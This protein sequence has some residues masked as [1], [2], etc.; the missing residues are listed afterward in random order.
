MV[1]PCLFGAET[2]YAL[3]AV[4]HDGSGA[5]HI[6][7]HGA[8]MACAR[9][10]LP[11]LPHQMR[12][13]YPSLF[14]VNGGRLYYD[15]GYRVEYSSPEVTSP[16]E[17]VR[18]LRA[19]DVVGERVARQLAVDHPE[20]RE[21]FC[22][23]ASIDYL[24]QTAWG[25]HESY[26]IRD[27]RP[28]DLRE[29]LVPFLVS[30]IVYTGAG[31]FDAEHGG[32]RFLIMPRASFTTQTA[33]EN[34]M[35]DRPIFSTRDSPLARA[36][37]RRLHVACGETLSSDLSLFL[38][39]GATA[40]VA[41]VLE[42]APSLA[43]GL[44]LR[45]PVGALRTIA[46]DPTCRRRVSLADGRLMSATGIQRGYL[47]LVESRIGHDWMPA[48]AGEVCTRW[49]EVLDC[50]DDDPASLDTAL[51]WVIKWR[52]Y[53]RYLT[54]HG[55]GPR[56]LHRHRPGA[57][58]S[59]QTTRRRTARGAAGGSCRWRSRRS[60]TAT[61]RGRGDL[62]SRVAGHRRCSACARVPDEALRD[63]HAMGRAWPQGRV[64]LTRRARR[65]R[66]PRR[67]MRPRRAGG[68]TS[69]RRGPCACSRRGRATP[70]RRAA[71]DHVRMGGHRRRRAAARLDGSVRT[72]GALGVS[73]V[74]HDRLMGGET[75]YALAARDADGRP[76]DQH[77]LVTG[78][79]AFARRALPYSSTSSVNRFLGNGCLL[80][81]DPT[82]HLEWSSAEC[83]SPHDAVRYLRA[84]DLIVERLVEEFAQARGFESTFC[85]RCN[86][87]YLSS[88]SW[89]S[90]ESYAHRADPGILPEQLVPFLA[91]RVIY[92]G[93]GGWDPLV[94][95]LRFMLAPRARFTEEAVGHDSQWSRP[96]FHL[97]L[98]SLSTTGT[99]RLHVLCGES[100]CSDLASL[101]RFG[102]TALVVAIVEAGDTPG[103]GLAMC[104]PVN[105]YRKMAGDA[106]CREA[107]RLRSGRTCTAIEL[108]RVLPGGGRAS[109]RQRV[110][111]RVG[112]ADLRVVASHAP[113]PRDR[114]ATDRHVARLGHQA[115]RLRAPPSPVGYRVGGTRRLEHPARAGPRDGGPGL[116]EVL[117]PEDAGGEPA[118][119]D[120]G[121]I[122]TLAPLARSMGL[123]SRELPAFLA[124]RRAAF[125]IDMRFGQLGSAGVFVRSTAPACSRTRSRASKTSR[126][127][128]SSRRAAHARHCGATSCA[129]CHRLGRGTALSGHGSSISTAVV[130]STSATRSR[131][132]S[133]GCRWHRSR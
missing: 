35:H 42:R 64:S 75:E 114:R 118:T 76:V 50:L 32:M 80:G 119:L 21:V 133:A 36:P 26:L 93:A 37:Y 3:A 55:F 82:A 45:H 44:A 49:R 81:V 61:P 31:G 131:Q 30:R 24:H 27:C 70:V 107:I 120:A 8:F 73:G 83:T 48:W 128:P 102:A 123:D 39:T 121:A 51:D 41:R 13:D 84:G 19:G 57:R 86:V 56:E 63:R 95:G 69:P 5:P 87:D 28:A 97:K 79:M 23:R 78:V 106:S 89:A 96:I 71:P 4:A 124:A 54:Q 94:P 74:S 110:A 66:A 59:W 116:Y 7:V 68:R 16:W 33:A 29:S 14:L 40:L 111:S 105:A 53:R 65:T 92:A 47:D 85:S 60:G 46:A 109:A 91:S 122:E 104:A 113:R 43:A 25:A 126:R 15:C 52:L 12:D 67:G 6:V 34:T 20:W 18:Y 127:P 62:R 130:C 100:L 117:R 125:E 1:E 129:G 2:E 90:H 132:W 10:I 17:L 9:R 38:R 115:R 77:E 88:T 112:W 11:H 99:H 108:Q 72:R 58:A 22:S 101:L 103:A 98:E